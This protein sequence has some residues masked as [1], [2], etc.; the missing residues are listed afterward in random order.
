MSTQPSSSA[1]PA[2]R[3]AAADTG[4]PSTRS[5]GGARPVSVADRFTQRMGPQAA[6]RRNPSDLRDA[7][8]LLVAAEGSDLH[9]TAGLPPM[10]RQHG[11]LKVVPG[12]PTWDADAVEREVTALL[13]PQQQQQFSH[14]HEL[15]IAYELSPQARFRMNV[16]RQR[17]V[18]GAVMRHIS[19]Q[20]RS[21]EE[22]GMPPA[23]A[24]FANLSKGLVL[25]TGPTGSGKSTTL[26]AMVDKINRSRSEHIMTVE[27][28]IEYLHP[29][30]RSI[31]NQRQVGDDTESFARALRQMLRQ[32]PDVI[33]IGE[34]RDWETISVALTA[35]ETGH[36]VFATLHTQ[37][38]PQT[39]DRIIDVFPPHQQN[40][41]RSQLSLT[42]KGVVCQTLIPRNGG[43]RVAATEVLVMT[44][45]I[46]NLIRESQLQQLPGM[47]QAGAAFGMHTYD[48]HLLKLVEDGEIAFEDGED[49]A[50]DK[51]NFRQRAQSIAR[52]TGI[53]RHTPVGH[54][55]GGR[56]HGMRSHSTADIGIGGDFSWKR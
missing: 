18:V 10:M 43:G 55:G 27:D 50:A 33:L 3:P 36:L 39:L 34:M 5:A 30:K 54:Q 26:A 17:G 47:L 56:R 19:T 51:E 32:D 35:A 9:I 20:I 48:Q 28:P 6:V 38:A 4:A 37:S 7:L 21:L 42:L 11:E 14:E 41:I 52:T 49:R 23:V 8:S 40:Q 45:A 2:R 25:V 24:G 16:F 15:D 44:P 12:F 1:Q 29:H 13:S 53:S 31:V 46:A 22:L